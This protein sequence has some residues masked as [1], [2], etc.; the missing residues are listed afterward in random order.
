MRGWEGYERARTALLT[1]HV[2]TSGQLLRLGANPAKFPSMTDN[3]RT[4]NNYFSERQVTFHALE[5]RTLRRLKGTQ[6]AHL[7]GVAEMRM[8]LG[9]TPGVHWESSGHALNARF[10]PDA[11]WRPSPDRTILIE[12]DSGDYPRETIHKKLAKFVPQGK[13]FWGMTSALR[14]SR[15]SIEYPDVH[16]ILALWWQTP[17]ERQYTLSDIRRVNL[18]NADV[19]QR[20]H[21]RY[22]VK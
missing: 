11:I 17:E 5:E 3:V 7:A 9:V 19:L 2:L 13:V 10:K 12:F 22:R 15:W 14:A 20:T 1:D 8:E 21:T 18:R 6:L 4:T 16:F